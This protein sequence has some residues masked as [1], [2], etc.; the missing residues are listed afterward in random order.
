MV[1]F[2]KDPT[3][4]IPW[5]EDATATDVVHIDTKQVRPREGREER[6]GG[7]GGGE[8]GCQN[9]MGR[10]VESRETEEVEGWVTCHSYS[11]RFK[12]NRYFC[13][14]GTWYLRKVSYI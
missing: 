3:G 9:G 14:Y 1:N 7:K 6:R 10:R 13:E 11:Y 12:E 4:D 5:E 8:S 2:M